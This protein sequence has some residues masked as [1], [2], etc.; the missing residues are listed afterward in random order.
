MKYF[1][2]IIIGLLS[3]T[4]CTEIIDIE[5]NSAHQRIVVE[6]KITDQEYSVTVSDLINNTYVLVQKG[7]KNYYI[8]EAV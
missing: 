7:K 5:L 3:L 8:I 2:Y 6:A 4:S 1:L